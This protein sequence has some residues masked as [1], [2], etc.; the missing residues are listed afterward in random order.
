MNLAG[1]FVALG[2][3]WGLFLI[4]FFI[5]YGLVA[6]PKLMFKLWSIEGRYKH[7]IILLASLDAELMDAK[8]N[9]EHVMNT[10]YTLEN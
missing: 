3:A 2:N 4:I 7:A 8:F 10:V 6:I 5:G 1:F 9:L